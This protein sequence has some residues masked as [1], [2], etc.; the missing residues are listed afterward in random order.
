MVLSMKEYR[1]NERQ[2]AALFEKCGKTLTFEDGTPLV[3]DDID[4][5]EPIVLE[6][7]VHCCDCAWARGDILTCTFWSDRNTVVVDPMNFCSWGRLSE[8]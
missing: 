2:I 5:Y 1:I 6:E 3:S 8:S 4:R 7:I